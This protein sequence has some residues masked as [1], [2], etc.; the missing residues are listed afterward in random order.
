MPSG[1]PGASS[2]RSSSSV[3]GA[4]AQGTDPFGV[5]HFRPIGQTG[6]F[7]LQRLW[8]S[9]KYEEVYLKAYESVSGAKANLGACLN[10]FNTRRPH[11]SLDGKTPHTIYYNGLPQEKIS[12]LFPGYLPGGGPVDNPTLQGYTYLCG[13]P[14]QSN[15]GRLCKP[16]VTSGNHR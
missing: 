4:A 16:C 8:K 13:D 5:T 15:G 10:F 1:I 9:I 2:I 14:V 11:P 12:A 7:R 6:Q 3:A